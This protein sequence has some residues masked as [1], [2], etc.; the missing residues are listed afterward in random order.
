MGMSWCRR[1]VDDTNGAG[2]DEM[3]RCFSWATRRPKRCPMTENLQRLYASPPSRR[4]FFFGS[5]LPVVIN[6]VWTPLVKI[7]MATVE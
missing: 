7:R 5:E 4:D 3:T 1:E 6:E 2:L